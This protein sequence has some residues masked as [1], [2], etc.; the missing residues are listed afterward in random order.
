M[1]DSLSEK[2]SCQMNGTYFL[3]Y[4]FIHSLTILWV[5]GRI[6]IHLQRGFNWVFRWCSLSFSKT[7][8]N[9]YP[10]SLEGLSGL[11]I[12]S[13]REDS[14]IKVNHMKSY[15]RGESHFSP[16]SLQLFHQLL[17]L[18]HE[19]SRAP[20]KLAGPMWKLFNAPFLT[21]SAPVLLSHL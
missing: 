16:W 19:M 6:A 13:E 12:C 8:P 2:G 14:I 18:L 15:D 4:C 9:S 5:W 10:A 7:K 11:G 1:A 17:L 21:L 3:K 20:C